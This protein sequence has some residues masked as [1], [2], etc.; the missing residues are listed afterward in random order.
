MKKFYAIALILG[1]CLFA[2]K[3]SSINFQSAQ[4]TD[5]L[6]LQSG[7]YVIYR[8]DS[9]EFVNFGTQSTIVSYQAM[10]VIDTL[11][12]DNLG[13][14]TWRV[15]RYLSD[16]T[17]TAPW[18]FNET[19]MITPTRNDIELVENNLRFIKLVLPIMNGFNWPGNSYIDT[20]VP[21]D[22]NGSVNNDPDLSY[23]ANWNYVYDSVGDP[24]L[25]AGGLVSNSLIV[26]QTNQYYGDSTNPAAPSGVTYSQEVYGK[27]IGLIHKNLVHWEY[28][29][30][31]IQDPVAS[32]FG[33]GITLNMISH[34]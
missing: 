17:G 26:N 18:A 25:T 23:F 12:T 14:P 11:I 22:T 9:L 13:Q 2:C 31:N 28:Q 24:Y 29:P 27:G 19:Y 7:K 5:Y 21:I 34:N 6:Q 15:N 30:P 4:L 3:R 33:Y 32:Y 20:N 16:T 10:D 8:L 1:I